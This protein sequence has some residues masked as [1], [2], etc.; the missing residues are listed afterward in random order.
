M[1]P[2]LMYCGAA[3][4]CGLIIG[5]CSGFA[6]EA[7]TSAMINATW[8]KQHD[9][10]FSTINSMD[11]MEED[12]SMSPTSSLYRFSISSDTFSSPSSFYDDKPDDWHGD[13]DPEEI[14]SFLRQR[15]RFQQDFN[16]F[17]L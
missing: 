14:A 3:S 7:I 5:G 12:E 11:E 8:G 4:I 16:P 17:L 10:N 13:E 6:V 9:D 2:V 1:Y 15:R